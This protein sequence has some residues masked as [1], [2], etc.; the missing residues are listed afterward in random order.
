MADPYYADDRVRLWQGDALAVLAGLPDG[1]VDALITDPPYSSGGMTRGDRVGPDP[2]A[3]YVQS[4]T[5]RELATF[6]GDNRDQRG[7]GYWCALWLGEALRVVRP[8]GGVALFADWRQLP[9]TTDILQ[10]A[11]FVWRG[12]VPWVKPNARPQV[13][14][15]A[16]ACEYVVWGSAG[17]MPADYSEPCLPGF[18]HCLSPRDRE[19][20]TQ[21]PVDVMR[22]LVR[23]APPGGVVLDPFMGAGTTGV[24]AVIES[25]RFWGVEIT[26][27]FAAVARRRILH[28]AGQAV[29][30][31]DQQ[32]LRLSTG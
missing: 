3:K 29:P 12:V 14:R 32:T 24:A 22:H 15:F 11:G 31:G 4:G 7:Y 20:I 6:A 21:K 28:A 17:P 26:D 23:I 19:H 5:A 18:L 1:S 9:T 2:N 13:G 27:H 10:A 30:R 25:R 16:A 8:G